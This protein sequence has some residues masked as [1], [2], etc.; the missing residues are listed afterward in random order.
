MVDRLRCFSVLKIFQLQGSEVLKF[1]SNLD[2]DLQSQAKNQNSMEFLAV[3]AG[4]A[5]LSNE[6]YTGVGVRLRGDST[7]SLVWAEEESSQAGP[8]E[9]AALAFMTLV[10]M[11][12]IYVVDGTH[13]RGV[14]N[15]DCDGL[16]RGLKEEN[17]YPSDVIRSLVMAI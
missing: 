1:A 5:L 11:T 17:I 7:T 2:F 16:S 6:G 15:V 12:H 8:S 13:L 4:M 10:R 9:S 3:V 14:L